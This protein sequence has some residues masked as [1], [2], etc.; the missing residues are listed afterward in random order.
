MKARI[1]FPDNDGQRLQSR[2]SHPLNLLLARTLDQVEAVIAEAHAQARAGRWVIGF[3]A[4]EAAPAFDAA[5]RVREPNGLL[6]LAAFAVYA[7][8]DRLEPVAG[9]AAVNCGP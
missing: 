3:V 2:F 5:L 8:P 1:D 6:P 7:A 4:Y 9:D